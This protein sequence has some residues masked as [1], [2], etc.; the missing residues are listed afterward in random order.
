[1]LVAIAVVFVAAGC[2]GQSQHGQVMSYL[3]LVNDT[4]GKLAPAMKAVSTANEAY[5]KHQAGATVDAGLVKAGRT[6]QQERRQL[7][8]IPA[9]KA[10]EHL[11]A[12][13]LELLDREISLTG[14]LHGLSIFVPRFDG[15]LHPLV[16]ADAALKRELGR[17]AKGVAAAKALDSDKAKALESY[18]AVI[19]SVVAGLR[20]LQPPAVWRPAYTSQ[21]S[22][23]EELRTTGTA[24]AHAITGGRPAVVP[25]LLRRFDAASLAGQ[26]LASQRAQIAAVLAYDS[27]V[28]SV[29]TIAR[30]IEAE[31]NRLQRVTT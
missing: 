23:L 11:R 24:L 7:A 31:R 20:K 15:E 21:L 19:D 18:A 14:E 13:L 9:P 25:S 30:R 27:R 10:A 3:K 2:G 22:A 6:L 4:E 8:A 5:A 26:S 12:L 1:M 16:G 17:S 29:E 28:R